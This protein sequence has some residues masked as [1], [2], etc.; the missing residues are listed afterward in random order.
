MAENENLELQRNEESVGS[1]DYIDAINGLKQELAQTAKKNEALEAEARKLRNQFLNERTVETD[2]NSPSVEEL[3]K[4][5]EDGLLTAPDIKQVENF[6]NLR[7]K[8]LEEGKM[9]PAV[10]VGHT[11]TATAKDYD[12]ADKVFQLL[13]YCLEKAD[14][15]PDI[16][17]REL[18][19]YTN[20]RR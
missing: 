15:D 17:S 18:K 11:V 5:F 3:R 13:E 10:P 7:N 9:D 12:Q 4:T 19:K 20:Q 2:D 1:A 14:G 16:F 8:L 6:V